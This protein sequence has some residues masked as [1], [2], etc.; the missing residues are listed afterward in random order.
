DGTQV[1]I[2][3][4]YKIVPK[5][6]RPGSHDGE[7]HPMD[8]NE[9]PPNKRV[10]L[11][12]E[13]FHKLEHDF[14]LLKQDTLLKNLEM[15][16]YD[17]GIEVVL[18]NNR[19]GIDLIELGIPLCE[20]L[21][22]PAHHVYIEILVN[23]IQEIVDFLYQEASRNRDLLLKLQPLMLEYVETRYINRI[24][25]ALLDILPKPN[26]IS[27]YLPILDDEEAMENI[28]QLLWLE[29]PDYFKETAFQAIER[30]TSDSIMMDLSCEINSPIITTKIRASRQRARLDVY[31]IFI[32][33]DLL[34]PICRQEHSNILELLR[35]IGDHTQLY[36]IAVAILAELYSQ[37][38]LAIYCNLR[39]DL[40][41]AFHR[42]GV[43]KITDFD[44][45]F[46][47]VWLLEAAI[48]K[49]SPAD[50]R[51]ASLYNRCATARGGL[52]TRTTGMR[53]FSALAMI[54][55]ASFAVDWCAR[56]A[57][58]VIWNSH[59][60]LSE[61]KLLFDLIEMG[62]GARLATK[63]GIRP[64]V[65]DNLP[66]PIEEMSKCLREL[67]KRVPLYERMT[68]EQKRNT[69][70]AMGGSAETNEYYNLRKSIYL[71]VKSNASSSCLLAQF[72]LDRFK[73]RDYVSLLVV[74]SPKVVK[75]WHAATPP[76]S[77]PMWP[78]GWPC[79]SSRGRGPGPVPPLLRTFLQ[80][81]YQQPERA[82][83]L[84][85]NKL[86]L[87]VIVWKFFVPLAIN[88]APTHEAVLRLILHIQFM[89]QQHERG[90][91]HY[92]SNALTTLVEMVEAL[93]SARFAAAPLVVDPLDFAFLYR[94][95][96][97][98]QARFGQ[99]FAFTYSNAPSTLKLL[100]LYANDPRVRG[101]F[102]VPMV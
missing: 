12:E 66:Y 7:A 100:D 2:L 83:E 15:F 47:F 82:F 78:S 57:F 50:E 99:D 1:S 64:R 61:I 18:R 88:H 94:E 91:V 24:C 54:L 84:L 20:G 46:Q 45:I 58:Q 92:Y 32:G 49:D 62:F 6:E 16:G 95:I 70:E 59:R 9:G 67:K 72:V 37:S 23:L 21:G 29:R 81:H 10:R 86:A 51:I 90:S 53:K 65:A 31:G 93:A 56:Q 39:F 22:I 40:L 71:Q 13:E 60:H 89:V 63:F 75:L 36:D 17:E 55:R 44:P 98:A 102:Q 34:I 73:L 4:C 85:S 42:N 74:F 35:L 77:P 14:I 28:K 38:G 76:P 79:P 25:L 5:D 69:F 96:C 48:L 30:Y 19:S 26:D 52:P 41:M 101:G 11:S 3:R 87:H 8:S 27:I 97:D 33:P 43:K 68:D 80:I